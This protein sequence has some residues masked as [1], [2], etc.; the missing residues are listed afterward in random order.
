M[1]LYFSVD[2]NLQV[3]KIPYTPWEIQIGNSL[4]NGSFETSDGRV[5]TLIGEEGQREFTL[6]SFFPE[7]PGKYKW[8]PS[9]IMNGNQ[10]IDFFKNNRKKIMRVVAVGPSGLNFNMLCTLDNFVYSERQNKDITYNL[11]VKEYIDPN[12]VKI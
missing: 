4:N 12:E 7:K 8:L 11:T 10:Y 5:L 2:K 3:I 1:E 9:D 6:N